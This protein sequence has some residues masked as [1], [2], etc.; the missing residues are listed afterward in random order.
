MNLGV[1]LCVWS[2]FVDPDVDL[3]VWVWICGS[4]DLVV[5]LRIWTWI[6]GFVDLG[7][8]LRV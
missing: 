2:G 4:V 1:D 6:C 5:D 3:R 8:D 7:V